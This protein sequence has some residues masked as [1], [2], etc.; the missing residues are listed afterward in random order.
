VSAVWARALGAGFFWDDHLLVVDNPI[1]R[2]GALARIFGGDLW[3][4]AVD[5]TGLRSPFFRPL[6]LLSF[7]FDRTIAGL[8]PRVFHLDNLA[9][10]LLAVALVVHLARPRLGGPRA[11]VAGALFGLHPIQS[12]AVVWIAA[13]NDLLCAVGVLGALLAFDRGHRLLGGALVATAA[14]SKEAGLV[15]PALL[16]AWRLAD[17]RRPGRG[18]L[19]AALAGITFALG[20][21]ARADLGALAFA[22]IDP[23]LA[24]LVPGRVAVT[25]L[26]WLPLP[27]PLTSTASFYR[28][29]PTAGEWLLAGA[30][31]VGLVAAARARAGGA[32]LLAFAA[33]AL[34]PTFA[35]MRATHTIGERFLY[36]PLVG[37]AILI[38]GAAPRR[39]WPVGLIGGVLAIGAVEARLGEW[40]DERRLWETA[41]ARAPDGYA[42]LRVAAFAEQDG[43][44]RDA[45]QAYRHAVD[46]TPPLRFAC[47]HPVRLLLATGAAEPASRLGD[48]LA[49]A[50]CTDAPFV[51][52]WVDA[53]AYAGRLDDAR[54]A[55]ARPGASLATRAAI[56]LADGDLTRAAGFA[57]AAPEGVA[58]LL[59]AAFD[60]TAAPAPR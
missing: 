6:V 19:L 27:W 17:R 38:A 13:R 57:L 60:R 29:A 15:A 54:I 37:L 11:L 1:V 41:A 5:A 25:L 26:D 9:W 22:P 59:D 32:G 36:L 53:L 16:V 31:V 49:S 39:S 28:A 4:G 7:V 21:R 14:L 42:W 33:I 40:G 55:A 18:E 50:G 56:A 20:L 47:P 3:E 48:E 23:D 2:D 30:V 35:A 10:H 58:A 46:A 51:E 44:P 24:P 34:A 45:F 12:E 43:R 52:Q 8:D